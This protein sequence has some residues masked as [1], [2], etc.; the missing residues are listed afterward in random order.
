M[1]AKESFV[2]KLF[3]GIKNAINPYSEYNPNNQLNIEKH[4]GITAAV[5]NENEAP[6]TQD[7]KQKLVA[8]T[9]DDM[10]VSYKQKETGAT[11]I[12]EAQREADK[13][14]FRIDSAKIEIGLEAIKIKKILAYEEKKRLAGYHEGVN[15]K[16]AQP[17]RNSLPKGL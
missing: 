9:M 15:E 14:K 6:K 8:R 2:V 3:H 5:R 16:P 17:R 13:E 12:N 11:T 1:Q 4:S 7:V 10:D